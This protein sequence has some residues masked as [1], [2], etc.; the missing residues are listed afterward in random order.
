MHRHLCKVFDEY[1]CGKGGVLSLADVVV[2]L[3]AIFKKK[4]GQGNT[5]NREMVAKLF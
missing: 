4:T 3:N 2:M 5:M 1:A